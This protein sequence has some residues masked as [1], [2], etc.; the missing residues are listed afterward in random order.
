L[1]ALCALTLGCTTLRPVPPG[2]V[3][4]LSPGQGLLAVHIDS[5]VPIR[6]LRFS[7]GTAAEDVPAGSHLLLLLVDAG[8]YRWTEIV[9]APQLRYPVPAEWA[10]TFRVKSGY[11]NYVGHIEIRDIGSEQMMGRN[12]NRSSQAARELRRLHP[13]L[14]SRFPARYAGRVRDDF[15]ER[16]WS[17]VVRSLPATASGAEE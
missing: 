9:L 12:P 17:T 3:P 4:S 2:E 5:N 14:A 13:E 6:Q 10:W 8:S 16:Y 15:L 7:R 1:V 11:I